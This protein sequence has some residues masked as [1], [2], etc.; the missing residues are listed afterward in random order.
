MEEK[1]KTTNKEELQHRQRVLLDELTKVSEQLIEIMKD[2]LYRDLK[3]QIE[4]LD[5]KKKISP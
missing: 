4:L 2:E 3:T 5:L 1:K